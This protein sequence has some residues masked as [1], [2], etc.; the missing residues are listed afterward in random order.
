MSSARK[1]SVGVRAVDKRSRAGDV[2]TFDVFDTLLTRTVIRPNDVF[3]NLGRLLAAE[4]LLGRHSPQAFAEARVLADRR[5]HARGGGREAGIDLLA[6]WQELC[7]SL[8]LNFD[9]V[10]T[11]LAREL[12]VE[13]SVLRAV[14][15]TVRHLQRTRESSRI[16]LISDTYLTRSQLHEL[17]TGSGVEVSLD[18]IYTSCDARAA[19]GTGRLFEV[20]ARELGVNPDA[21]RHFGDD[22]RADVV[23]A[24]KV[25]VQAFHVDLARPTRYEVLLGRHGATTDGLASVLAGASRMA[26]IS[27]KPTSARLAP[28]VEV[29]AGVAA[30]A[31]LAYSSWMLQR[32]RDEG[33]RR[34]YFLSRD[35]QVIWEICRRIGPSLGWSDDQLRYLHVSRASLAAPMMLNDRRLGPW[36]W[37]HL[38]S[39]NAYEVLDRV[40]GSFEALQDEL[41]RLGITDPAR[42]LGTERR[43]A[44][45]GSLE[46]GP[47]NVALRGQLGH[48]RELLRRYLGQE[49]FLDDCPV[50]VVDLGGRGSQFQALAAAR[51]A[52]GVRP[53]TGFYSY[54]ISPPG[55]PLYPGSE[56]AWLFDER[57]GVGFRRFPGMVSM[58]EAFCAADHGSVRSYVESEDV[59][60]PQFAQVS[61]RATWGQG[62]MRETIIRAA[63]ALHCDARLVNTRADTR[64]AVMAAARLFWLEPTRGEVRAWAQF[65]VE[66]GSGAEPLAR[67]ASMRE[68]AAFVSGRGWPGSW[69]EWPTACIE[70]GPS[71]V[72]AWRLME[73]NGEHGRVRRGLAARARRLLNRVAELG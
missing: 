42:P 36:V 13:A 30:V 56:H 58:L 45:Q 37:T 53:P 34:L 65:P 73:D 48:Q 27:M 9:D 24:R 55:P 67:P 33:L 32:A 23:G 10:N 44:L 39:A 46:V 11:Y 47:G 54:L 29:A 17:L 8:S 15:P 35:G 70:L 3:L 57:R 63:E 1:G 21:L 12:E 68:A 6:I 25:G 7:G 40:G 43:S 61:P 38:E 5:A 72:R 51:D 16:A 60:V 64:T 50:G 2:V 20:V 31:L 26:R 66:E 19:K 4:G 62:A 14:D 18:D 22:Q 69:W 71:R 52:S 59:I 28:V 49:G 41:R